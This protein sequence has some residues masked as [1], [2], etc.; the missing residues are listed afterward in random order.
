MVVS[1]SFQSFDFGISSK[2]ASLF[3][4]VVVSTVGL[5]QSGSFVEQGV[6]TLGLIVVGVVGQVGQVGQVGHV[7]HVGGAAQG[8][9]FGQVAQIGQ[10]IE[11]VLGV[12][13]VVVVTGV[14]VGQVG[15]VT[16]GGQVVDCW[17]VGI[18]HGAHVDVVILSG[19]G[20]GLHVGNC[21]SN[22]CP[23]L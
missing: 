11:V 18:L 23:F 15:H 14:G 21:E 6:H 8:M 13:V 20:H 17:V 3:L 12:V 9:D 22:L 10:G 5:L 1:F 19:L 2:L 16:L 4:L 7:G